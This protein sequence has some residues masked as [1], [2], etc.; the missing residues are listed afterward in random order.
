[1]NIYYIILFVCVIASFL[2]FDLIRNV[3]R[4][5]VKKH[6]KEVSRKLLEMNRDFFDHCLPYPLDEQQ[7]LSIVSEKKNCLVV[8]SAGSG[9]T[10]SIVGKVK[11]LIEK[12]GIDPKKIL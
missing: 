11:Y 10:S 4:W 7:R 3:I 6:N 8:S 9:K 2:F 5:L 1:M 12:K